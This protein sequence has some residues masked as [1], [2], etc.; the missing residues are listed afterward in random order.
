LEKR[1]CLLGSLFSSFSFLVTVELLAAL[2]SNMMA[3]AAVL[4]FS[5]LLVKSLR[6]HSKVSCFLAAFTL[7]LVL[8]LH[9]YTWSFMIIILGCL[10]SIYSLRHVSGLSSMLKLKFASVITV[11]NV[12]VEFVRSFVQKSESVTVRSGANLVRVGASLSFV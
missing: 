4:F 12:I 8:F 7:V 2:I 5:G 11:S 1:I 10:V 6:L 3:W 9:V